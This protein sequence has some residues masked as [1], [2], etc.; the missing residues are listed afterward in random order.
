MTSSVPAV[1]IRSVDGSALQAVLLDMDGTL[2]D[3]EGFWWD[4]EVE[5]FAELGHALDEAHREVVVGGPMTRSLGH[6]ISVTGTDA[7]LAE[8]SALINLRFTEL[9]GRGVPLMPGA[10]RLLTELA[11]H[12]VPTALVSAS[13][14][15]VIDTVLV[16]LGPEHFAFSLAGDEVTRTKPHPDPYLLAAAR[17]GADPAR[18]V[19]I[20]D[21]PTGVRAAEAAGCRVVAVPSIAPIGPAPG[22]TVVG[23]LEHVDLSFLRSLVTDAY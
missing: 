18:C 3:T 14:R 23:S 15:R 13:H 16:S 4:A 6:L 9:I 7:T 22:R 1:D 8:L 2:V 10:R 21:T 5:V 20:E 12:E 17:L 11:A 19:V